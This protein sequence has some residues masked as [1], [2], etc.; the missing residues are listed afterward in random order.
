MVC[1]KSMIFKIFIFWRLGLFLISALGLTLFQNAGL[2]PLASSNPS[3][4]L[5]S[6][7]QWDGG[8]Y[9][10]I[11]KFG[12]LNPSDFAF[13]PLYPFLI[14]FFSS[15]L[16]NEIFWGLLISNT[17]FLIFLQLFYN[18]LSQKYSSKIAFNSTILYLLFP[19]TFFTTTFYSESLFL[20]LAYLSF[21]AMDNKKYLLAA[22]TI[23]LSSLTRLLGAALVISFFYKYFALLKSQKL[24]LNFKILLPF[25]SALGIIIYSSYLL[26]VAGNFLKF[27]SVQALWGR[28]IVDPITTI[29]SYFWTFMFEIKPPMDYLDFTFTIAFLLVLILGRRKISSSLWIF[30]MLA[31]LIPASSGTL[32]STPRYLLSSIGAFIIVGK[33]LEEKPVLKKPVWAISLTLQIIL[34]I[35]FLGGFWVA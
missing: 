28:E 23:N 27:A 20:L 18:S 3:S 10:E 12:Y 26:F 14:R 9:L 11:A 15:F 17:A 30:S 1:H 35:R 31:I 5:D 8:H 25:F 32:T 6:L 4:Y 34:Y 29:L 19:T 13:F 22:L 33:Y 24:S 7:L 21:W 16:G 2:I